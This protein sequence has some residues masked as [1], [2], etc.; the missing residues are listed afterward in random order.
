MFILLAFFLNYVA[1]ASTA[2]F[3]ILSMNNFTSTNNNIY[4]VL[5]LSYNEKYMNI[6]FEVRKKLMKVFV[7]NSTLFFSNT[8]IR[9]MN[10]FELQVNIDLERKEPGQKVFKK[11]FKSPRIEWCKFVSGKSSENRF[12]KALIQSFKEKIPQL[13]HDC[14]Y[15]GKYEMINASISKKLITILPVSLYFLVVLITEPSS[16][17]T[18]EVKI[19]VETMN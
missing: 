3:R 14:P 2:D 5:S 15:Q 1:Y 18:V 6:S 10:L 17:A 19:Y 7:S 11:V 9:L 13:F 16:K 12:A 8:Y 4:E